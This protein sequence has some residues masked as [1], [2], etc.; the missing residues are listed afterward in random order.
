M[1]T[2]EAVASIAEVMADMER[3][4][5]ANAKAA[6]Q[7]KDAFKAISDNDDA[8][9]LLTSKHYAR[10][11]AL[12]AAHAAELLALHND[13]TEDAKALG[14]DVPPASSDDDGDIGV[15]SGGGR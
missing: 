1:Q 11:V 4:A 10:L 3:R 2:N 15:L 14:I 7:A 6:R 9:P 12:T 5:H 8:P 13:M